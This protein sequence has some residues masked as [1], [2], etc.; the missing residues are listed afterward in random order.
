MIKG[1]IFDFDGVIADTLSFTF[2]E[3]I[4]NS[5]LL[6]AKNKSENEIIEKIRESN[7]QKLMKDFKISWLKL[8]LILFLIKRSQHKLFEQIDRFRPFINIKKTLY[9]IKKNNLKLFLVSSNIKKNIE[10]FLSFHQLNYFEKIYTP[11]NFF[12]K[13]KI[14]L[15]ILKGYQFKKQEVIYIG[16]ELRDLQAAKK[17]GIKFIG[18]NWGLAKEKVF[19]ENNADFIAKKPDDILKIVLSF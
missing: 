5:W 11:K 3:I 8:P 18:V 2:K 12:G 13:D 6:N 19:I 16:D 1:V 17:A 14:F 15:E 4:K 7:Y 10:K 9:K